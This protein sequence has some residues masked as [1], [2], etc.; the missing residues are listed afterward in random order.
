MISGHGAS[1]RLQRVSECSRTKDPDKSQKF[2][3]IRFDF[4][5]TCC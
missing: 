3:A 2:V 4:S 5:L 1:A